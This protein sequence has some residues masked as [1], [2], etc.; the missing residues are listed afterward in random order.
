MENVCKF[1]TS[2]HV[3]S[4]VQSEINKFPFVSSQTAGIGVRHLQALLMFFC[5][6]MA[7]AL[8]VNLSVGIVAMVDRNSTHQ[9]DFEVPMVT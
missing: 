9:P 5:L 8:R 1:I 2:N 7:Y 4:T 3:N 6:T